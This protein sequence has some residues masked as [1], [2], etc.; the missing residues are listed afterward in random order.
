[1]TSK[2]RIMMVEDHP[3]FREI[4]EMAVGKEEG[5]EI[6]SQFGTSERALRSLRNLR[7]ADIPDVVLLDL[8]LPGMDGL[9]ALGFFRASLPD[10]RIVILTQSDC[11]EDV[12]KSIMMG[13][14]GYLLKSSTL[15]QLVQGIRTVVSEGAIIDSKLA[16]F[17]LKTFRTK[18]PKNQISDVL[19][20]REIETLV[21]LADGLLKKEISEQLGISVSTVVTHVTHIYEKLRVKNA[22]AAVAKAFHLGILPADSGQ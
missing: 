20:E 18:L 3:E 22:P 5:M 16:G 7:T 19:T 14:D 11:E 6:T 21:L 15:R 9:E 10:A 17:M 2:I 13:A 1:M 12:L 8:R 4:V